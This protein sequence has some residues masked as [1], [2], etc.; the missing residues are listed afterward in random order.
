MSTQNDQNFRPEDRQTIVCLYCAKPQEVSRRAM[1]ITCKFCSKSLK[2]EDITIKGLA[3]S[4]GP[5]ASA[6]G[7]G[8]DGNAAADLAK[9]GAQANAQALSE[10]ER[11]QAAVLQNMLQ[12]RKR[13]A[14][15]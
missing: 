10:E 15:A 11:Q 12:R 6:L 4:F 5:V 3:G 8:S 9:A 7:G 2:L 1:T 14:F 13:G